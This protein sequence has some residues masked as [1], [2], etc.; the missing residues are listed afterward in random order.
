MAERGFIGKG[1]SWFSVVA[2]V[3]AACGGDDAA[4]PRPA[5]NTSISVIDL[6]VTDPWSRQPAAGQ[7]NAAVYMI[8]SNPTGTDITILNV[9]SPVTERVELHESVTNDNGTVRMQ[10]ITAGV[11]VP[12]GG[13]VSFEPGGA[14]VMM[15]D[16]DSTTYPTDNVEVTLETDRGDSITFNAE[17]R[18]L[19]GTPAASEQPDSGNTK[20]SS[21]PPPMPDTTQAVDVA[22]STTN[23]TTTEPDDSVIR[24]TID[25]IGSDVLIDD[26]RVDVP[27]GADVEL[28]VSADSVD[29]VHVHGYDFLGVVI[30]TTPAVLTFTANIPGV[31][32]V[33]LEEAG[34]LLLELVVS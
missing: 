1:L 22:Q 31:F 15:R 27:L 2:L 19:D 9:S 30:P 13:A 32:E 5:S 25:V 14:H 4:A 7:P 34:H 11:I 6:S 20:T 18:T 24:I 17:V 29:E 21:A 10:R 16:I 33:E 23:S 8:V 26:S 3:S 28:T 12:A